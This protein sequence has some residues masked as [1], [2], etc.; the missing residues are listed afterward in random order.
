MARMP[1]IQALRLFLF[2]WITADCSLGVAQQATNSNQWEVLTNCQLAASEDLDGDSFHVLHDGRQYIFRLYF[3]DAPETDAAL[4]DRI[5]DQAAYFGIAKE[6]VPRAGKHA[7]EFSR[8]F[9]SQTNFTVTTRWQNAMG[10][11]SLARFY[12]GIVVGDENLAEQLVA[13]GL[14]RIY[15]IRANFPGQRSTRFINTL[16]NLELS[17]REKNLGVWN[18][19][20]FPRVE[21]SESEPPA[22]AKSSMVTSTTD[23]PASGIELNTATRDQLMSLPGIGKVMAERIITNR[24][25]ASIEDLDRVPGVGPKTLEKL[26]PLVRVEATTN[27]PA[28]E[29]D[30]H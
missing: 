30:A 24:P 27:S 20:E 6:D 8:K 5:E 28:E 22:E 13:N 29:P 7:A 25:F 17:A 18:E 19:K 3:V 26:R 4:R 10:R 23:S 15:G 14:A 12:C 9:L 21:P 16:K 1:Y 11:S 2:L